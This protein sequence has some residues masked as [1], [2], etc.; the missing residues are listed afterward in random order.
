L[1]FKGVD[2]YWFFTFLINNRFHNTRKHN[3]II[4]KTLTYLTDILWLASVA[5]GAIDAI[6]KNNINHI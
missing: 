5:D 4:G 6:E 2:G 1:I 3:R